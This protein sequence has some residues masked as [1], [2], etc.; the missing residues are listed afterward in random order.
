[1]RGQWYNE[2][3]FRQTGRGDRQNMKRT[4]QE[5]N[6]KIRSGRAVAVTAEEIIDR[7]EQDGEEKVLREVDVVTTGTFSPMCSSG[8]LFNFGHNDP[9]IKMNR[10]LLNGVPAYAGLAAV[11]AYLGATELREGPTGDGLYGGAHV[12]EEL[13]AGRE[14]ELWASGAMTDCYPAR[15]CRHRISLES[16]NEAIMFNPRNAYQNYAAAVNGSDRILYTYMGVLFPHCKNMHYATSG[17]LSPLLNDPYCRTVGVGTR[18][19]L[20]GTAGYV[21]WNGTQFKSRVERTDNGVPVAPA[22]TLALIGNL[23]EMSPAYI[24]AAVME[25][26]GVSLFVGMGVPIPLLDRE[27][28]RQV[29]VRDEEIFTTI[30]DYGVPALEK[31]TYGRVSYAQLKSGQVELRGQTVRTASLSS[32]PKAREIARILKE[33]IEAGR[34][35]L[36]EPLQPFPEDA[37]VQHLGESGEDCHD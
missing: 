31:P 20:G 22:A 12:I 21:A 8:V 9:P 11:D 23:K 27:M 25:R 2:D 30:V 17:Q 18:I 16:I 4:V 1:M 10:T 26:Y 5:I 14:V 7:V 6:E 33:W 34:F 15:E 3:N 37:A 19:F 28:L 32:I 35:T 29:C 13:L 36:S 24:Q